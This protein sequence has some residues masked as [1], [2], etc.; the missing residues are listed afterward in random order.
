M[1]ENAAQNA[2]KK[3]KKK[4]IHYIS[5]LFS[6]Q[7]LPSHNLDHHIRVWNNACE[8]IASAGSARSDGDE[9]FYEKLLLACLFHD[10][11]LIKDRSEIHGR[12]SRDFC[13]E[14]LA[15]NDAHVNFGTGDLLEAIEHHDDK[16]YGSNSGTGSNEVYSLLTIADDLD[17]FGA[18]G[19]Y[20]YAEIYLIRGIRKSE[21]PALILENAKQ[22]FENF[23][24]SIY[25]SR[26]IL[27][28]YQGK[29]YTLNS[30]LNVDTFSEDPVQLI[31]WINR[32]IV[33]PQKNPFIYLNQ[34]LVKDFSNIRLSYFIQEFIQEI[35]DS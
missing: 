25:A 14:F 1:S 6:E 24:K 3:W 20:R 18:V 2:E 33:I 27:Q 12:I 29:Y 35:S 15:Q 34:S 7:W 13:E 22:R 26:D 4:V 8:L 9:Y 11:G 16:Q 21:M 10:T 31:E 28:T 19:V 17:A 32:E 30:V 23:E 5:S